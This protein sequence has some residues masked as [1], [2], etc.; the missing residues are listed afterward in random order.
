MP[1]CITVV[2]HSSALAVWKG[3][4]LRDSVVWNAL[5]SSLRVASKRTS[6][7]IDINDLGWS[8]CSGKSGFHGEVV[9]ASFVG[10]I[11][12]CMCYFLVG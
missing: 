1:L 12:L 2:Y 3:A 9:L 11:D 6:R 7:D 5:R 4:F 8:S 10:F